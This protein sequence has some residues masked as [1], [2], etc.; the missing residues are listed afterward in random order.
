[1]TLSSAVYRWETQISVYPEWSQTAPRHMFAVRR[2]GNMADNTVR[3]ATAAAG[4]GVAAYPLG[5]RRGARRQERA[6]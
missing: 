4:G 2:A 1:M 6:R 3:G 5:Y